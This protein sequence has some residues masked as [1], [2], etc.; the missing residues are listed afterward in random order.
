MRKSDG[1]DA[2]TSEDG[3]ATRREVMTAAGLGLAA[4]LAGVP[5]SAAAAEAP[6]EEFVTAD[7][8]AKKGDVPLYLY[9]KQLRGR[10]ESGAAEPRPVL[11]LVHGSSIS[12]RSTY[13]L[14]VPGAG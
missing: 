11:F 5:P 14:T 4:A 10:P 6:S 1:R 13:D 7:Y 3:G 2:M 12:G 8:W 9:R